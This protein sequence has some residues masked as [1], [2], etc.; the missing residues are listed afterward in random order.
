VTMASILKGSML[1]LA[2]IAAFLLKVGTAASSCPVEIEFAVTLSDEPAEPHE[3][4]WLQIRP[5]VMGSELREIQIGAIEAR[6]AVCISHKALGNGLWRDLYHVV[7]VRRDRFSRART[8]NVAEEIGTLNADLK[9]HSKPYLL[10]GPGRWGS[11][12]P[13][14]GI[15]V[16]WAQISAARCIVETG[17]EDMRVDP[18]QGSHFFQNIMSFGIG[19]FTVSDSRSHEDFLDIPWL[20]RQPA[21][22]ETEHVRVVAFKS[23]LKIAIDGRKNFGVIIKPAAG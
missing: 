16:K 11:S 6:D 22:S 18:S 3:F 2:D 21:E 14:L 5:L 1:P 17:F 10:I 9:K 23:P 13:W 20:D 19:Y 7:Y 8:A 15:P 12:D 4:A